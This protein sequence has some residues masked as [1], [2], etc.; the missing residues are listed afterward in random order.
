MRTLFRHMEK[1]QIDRWKNCKMRSFINC[2]FNS[3]GW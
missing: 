2:G 3:A 1:E